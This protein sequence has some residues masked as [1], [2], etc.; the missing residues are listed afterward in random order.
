MMDRWRAL[1]GR[2]MT[3]VVLLILAASSV[4]V[5]AF[6]KFDKRNPPIPTFQ[7]KRGEFLD[8][9]Q[10]RGEM[11]A[12]RSITISAPPNAGSL[13]I[14]KLVADGTQ[15]KQGDVVV[16]FDPSKTQQDLA[17][18]QSA[19]KSADADIEQSQAQGKLTEEQDTTAVMKAKYDVEVAR[20]DASKSEIVSKIDGA[21]A[22]L[23]LADAEQAL[24][25]AEAQLKSDIATD[26]A[27]V[28]SK[29]NASSKA[30]FDAERAAQSL[31]SM[32]LKAPAAGSI[33]LIPVWHDGNE[34]PFKAGERAWSGAP[35]AELPD[36]S[37]L[38]VT[39]RVDETERGRLAPGLP[40]TVQLDA[41]ADRQF[42]GKIDRIG[43][44]ATSDF[45]AGWPIPRNFDLQISLDQTDPRL[46]PGMTVQITVIVDRIANAIAIPSQASFLKSGQTVA[47]VWNGSEFNERS[48]QVERRSR[49]RILVSRG[50]RPGDQVALQDP[51]LKE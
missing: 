35:L 27:T 9:V 37:S 12:M 15:V 46:K 23:K 7:V 11:K 48:I 49:D 1:L 18:D 40:V 30:R 45:S 20:L 26:R 3:I 51:T 38:R 6:V 33:S 22:N 17:Q 13:Q 31:A 43:T 16:Q 47:Y 19:L 41:I 29:R 4:A 8:A 24:K 42:T 36:A 39:A 21:E 10:F 2:R 14:L 5:F 34:G 50:L 44:I 32:T 28:E 25:Q